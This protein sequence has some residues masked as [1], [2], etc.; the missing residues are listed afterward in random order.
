MA[1]LDHD[2]RAAIDRPINYEKPYFHKAISFIGE[3]VLKSPSIL[4]IGAGNGEFAVQARDVLKAKVTCLDY[5]EPH[6]KTLESLG[7]NTVKVDFDNTKGLKGVAEKM[8]KSF[9]I[10]TAFELIE[11]IFALDDF[12]AFVHKVLKPN[13]LII[14]STPNLDY[15]FFHIY[16]LFLGNIPVGEGHHVRFFNRQRLTQALVLDGFDV[17]EE[18]SHGRGTAYWE[19]IIREKGKIFELLIRGIGRLI[20][21]LTPRSSSK[22]YRKLMLVGRKLDTPLLGIDN[23]WRTP[24]YDS[25]TMLERRQVFQR[26]IK[27]R[28][29]GLFND[30]PLFRKF[31]DSEYEKYFTTT[32]SVNSSG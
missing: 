13:G 29:E 9:D 10:V 27:Y 16:S 7:F 6:L 20:Y 8:E 32:F 26:L 3:Y 28:R 17:I 4:D 1:K 2:I 12:L 24:V 19:R 15:S 11:H 31:F 5:A 14:I 25:L 21:T 30:M 22:K 23:A 18:L